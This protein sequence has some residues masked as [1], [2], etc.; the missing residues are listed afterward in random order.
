MV[1]DPTKAPPGED[2]GI[3]G[4]FISNIQNRIRGTELTGDAEVAFRVLYEETR[5]AIQKLENLL[6]K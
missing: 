3:T 5:D 6:Q 4:E 2:I 1:F